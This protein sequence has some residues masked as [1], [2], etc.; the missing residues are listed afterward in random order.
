[1][2]DNDDLVGQYLMKKRIDAVLPY[3]RGRLLD[4]GCGSNMLTKRYGGQGTGIDIR[5]WGN[6]DVVVTNTTHLPFADGSFDTITF[7]AVLNHI[8]NR[9]MV[10]REASRVL[11]PHGRII[12]TSISPGISRCWHFIRKPWD[13]D[14]QE[15]GIA[16][17]EVYG[18]S[19]RQLRQ[20][21]EQGGLKIL[22]TRSFNFCFNFLIIGAKQ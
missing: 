4:I 2:Y 9:E 7:L 21:L 22:A 16:E 19:R 12:V 11:S 13:A 10:L 14:Q 6:V 8:T 18:F 20:L 3:I 15:R 17:Y 5:Q 1:M